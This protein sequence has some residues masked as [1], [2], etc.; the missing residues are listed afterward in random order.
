MLSPSPLKPLTWFF[1]IKLSKVRTLGKLCRFVS[2]LF[3]G[4]NVQ[5]TGITP[6]EFATLRS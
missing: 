1:K 4:Y 5:N 2:P 3:T 6:L